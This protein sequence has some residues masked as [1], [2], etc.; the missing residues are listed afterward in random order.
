[1]KTILLVIALSALAFTASAQK[2]G[3]K[4][5]PIDGPPCISRSLDRSNANSAPVQRATFARRVT[6]LEAFVVAGSGS[7]QDNA[8]VSICANQVRA[9]IESARSST[10][11]NLF[12]DLFNRQVRRCI[13]SRNPHL[14]VYEVYFV[15]DEKCVA[16]GSGG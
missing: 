13:A 1:M 11:V 4:F 5:S 3:V 12:S 10:H 7:E 8:H 15:S 9:D 14:Q 6:Q 2:V 16:G